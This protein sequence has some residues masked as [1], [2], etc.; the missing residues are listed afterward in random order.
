MINSIWKKFLFWC[1]FTTFSHGSVATPVD[2]TLDNHHSFFVVSRAPQNQEIGRKP[3][4]FWGTSNL[5]CHKIEKGNLKEIWK[6]KE[7]NYVINPKRLFLELEGKPISTKT[8]FIEVFQNGKKNLTITLG[9]ILKKEEIIKLNSQFTLAL[10][11]FE[12]LRHMEGRLGDQ[13]I[14]QA[15][16]SDELV[17]NFPEM[18]KLTKDTRNTEVFLKMKTLTGKEIILAVNS[19]QFIVND[20]KNEK[21]KLRETDHDPLFSK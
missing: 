17:K 8:P 9:D 18:H 16:E 2:Y 12:I 3:Y 6:I 10:S 13:V 11:Q 7:F 1:V 19:P 15:V 21:D 14:Y 5:S 4:C 20:S